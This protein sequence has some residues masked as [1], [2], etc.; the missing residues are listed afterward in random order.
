M[1][2]CWLTCRHLGWKH[3][4]LTG[5]YN[6]DDEIIAHIRVASFVVADFTGHRGVSTLRLGL[7]LA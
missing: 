5:D 1:D 3:I 6:I 2:R 7:P 4:N